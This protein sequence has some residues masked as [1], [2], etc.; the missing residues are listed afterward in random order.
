MLVILQWCAKKKIISPNKL[1]YDG[2]DNKHNGGGIVEI[3]EVFAMLH[4]FSMDR[5]I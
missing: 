1:F 4:A 3:F 2:E 5:T